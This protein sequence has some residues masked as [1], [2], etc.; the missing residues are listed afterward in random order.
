MSRPT[1]TTDTNY[2]RSK[3][4]L[5][6]SSPY[7]VQT[8]DQIPTPIL[9]LLV[10]LGPTL[11]STA[12]LVDILMWRTKQPRQSVLVV[13]IW[14]CLC[15]WT[16]QC[17][18]FGLP[19][20]V[21]YKLARDWLF[22]KTCK[23]RR[24]AM[25]MRRREQRSKREAQLEE[26]YSDDE[27]ITQLR[28]EQQKEE[29]NELISRKIRP[30][31]EV[32]LDD[33]LEDLAVV[34]AFID[35]V[36]LQIKRFLV[37]VDG[38][39]ADAAISCLSFLMYT[40]PFWILI[41]WVA[42]AHLVFAIAGASLLVSPSPW[43]SVIFMSLRNNVVL[44]HILAAAW[45]YGVAFITTSLSFFD[46]KRGSAS[47][48]KRQKKRIAVKDW[49]S[50]VMT[51]AKSEKTKALQVMESK[52]TL[53]Q[54]GNKGTRSEM[55]FQ[56]EV[57]E[58]QRWWLGVNWTTNMMPSERGP[59]TDNQLKAIPAKEDFK[60]PEPTI[61]TAIISKEG[62]VVERATNKVWNWADGDW[63]VD[64]TGEMAGKIDHNGWEYGNNSWKQ[65][66]G[67]P[68]MQ[69]FTRRRRWCRRAKLV[70]RETDQELDDTI[71]LH[72]PELAEK[73]RRQGIKQLDTLEK[74]HP[75][76]DQSL[77]PRR[78]T[79][80]Q[81]KKL[82]RKVNRIANSLDN[83]IPY[84]PI[85]IGIDTVL[86]FIPVIGGFLGWFL[87]LYQIYLSTTFGIPLWLILRMMYNI[88]VDFA[89]TF[90]PLLGGFLHMFYKANLYNYEELS[91]WLNNPTPEYTERVKAGERRPSAAGPQ[92][93]EISWTQLGT[94][95]TQLV[96]KSIT[97]TRK[98]MIEEKKP[99]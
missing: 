71:G 37:H 12:K 17:L 16:W 57:Y 46:F 28:L 86:G 15:L 61:K 19:G 31:G 79:E 68:G 98:R 96:T 87:S 20:L 62:K 11:Q 39:R 56:F 35:H 41:C 74:K 32:S 33:T 40:W 53:E 23:S 48:S 6:F 36:R 1:A 44:K 13:L 7:K 30:E 84:S 42:G 2:S 70:E 73:A 38:S 26:D 47:K 8:L 10:V 5:S 24:E 9:K 50:S 54:D 72:V 80:N 97:D 94:D 59:W 21:V 85:P 27:R 92:P 78:M 29:E 34:N 55:I 67:T 43:F 51:R 22:V 18:A 88:T 95:V 99:E 93:G 63:W 89:F 83:A 52:E 64:M 82:L 14:I 3:N 25:E 58:N 49:I 60:L 90:I 81:R 75:Y 4:T 76:L 66:S 45:A 91:E 77:P 65:L 69:T